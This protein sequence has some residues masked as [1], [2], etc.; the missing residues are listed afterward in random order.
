MIQS[1]KNT[2]CNMMLELPRESVMQL[3]ANTT[4]KY[5]HTNDTAKEVLT[6]LKVYNKSQ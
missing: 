3:D 4:I 2:K 6:K 1:W 5:L